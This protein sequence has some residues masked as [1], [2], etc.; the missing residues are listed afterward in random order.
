MNK[1]KLW[2]IAAILIICGAGLFGSCSNNDN[3][4]NTEEFTITT[5]N[6]DGLPQAVPL[7]PTFGLPWSVMVTI[8]LLSRAR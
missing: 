8:P 3:F 5:L 2:L 7:L 1:T 6:V 4:V